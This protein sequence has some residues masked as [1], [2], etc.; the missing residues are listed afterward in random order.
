MSLSEVF[1]EDESVIFDHMR[2]RHIQWVWQ[3]CIKQWLAVEHQQWRDG[4]IELV[5]RACLD[6]RS[7]KPCSTLTHD[8]LKTTFL[9]TAH[10]RASINAQIGH[11][12]DVSMLPRN[13][14]G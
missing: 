7:Q 8:P 9:Q 12:H 6:E 2:Q 11:D 4:N 3:V 10:H 1:G 13:L 14:Q 5:H